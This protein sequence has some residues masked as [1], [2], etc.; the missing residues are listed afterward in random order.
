M[1]SLSLI[2]LPPLSCLQGQELLAH[3]CLL[4]PPQVATLLSSLIPK[5]DLSL[6]CSQALGSTHWSPEV[7]TLT[8]F[9]RLSCTS[10]SVP[11]PCRFPL[12]LSSGTC[13]IPRF[14]LPLLLSMLFCGPEVPFP[15]WCIVSLGQL[16]QSARSLA[17]LSLWP[18]F[19]LKVWE[20]SVVR[21]GS[22]ALTCPHLP[23]FCWLC[24][25]TF[26]F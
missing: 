5:H 22:P 21:V 8:A 19:T 3:G 11:V 12:L 2:F 9:P 26:H 16:Q 20:Q 13:H 24:H 15:C 18:F 10:P 6:L 17:A 14:H 7:F 1:A 23:T 4:A 25:L